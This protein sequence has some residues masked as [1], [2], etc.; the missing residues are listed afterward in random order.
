MALT[1]AARHKALKLEAE[2]QQALS[3]DRALTDRGLTGA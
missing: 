1:S 2:H 3:E